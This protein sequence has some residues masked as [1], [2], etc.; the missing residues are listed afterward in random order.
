MAVTRG[1]V[2][3]PVRGP[4][5]FTVEASSSPPAVAPDAPTGVIAVAGDT[6][7]S[8]SFSAPASNGGSAITGY[9]VTSSPSGLT[10]S[11]ASSP[12]VVTGLRNG[13]AY[14]F[15]A[16]AT[17]AIGTSGASSASAPVV[18]TFNIAAAFTG[19]DAGWVHDT[20]SAANL[21]QTSA[22]SGAVSLHS[23]IGYIADLGPSARP[24]LQ[25]TSAS[26][27]IWS[28]V[29]R[30]YGA[31]LAPALSTFTAGTGWVESGGTATA[32]AGTASTFSVP[33]TLT[34][35]VMYLVA[36]TLTRTGGACTAQFTGGT[37]VAGVA[38]NTDGSYFDLL[39]AGTGNTTLE[40]S[41]DA[42]FA[43]TIRQVRVHEV[44]SYTNM[45]ARY[46]AVDDFM[47]SANLNLSAS[48][49]L[50][51]GVSLRSY[52]SVLA[53]T[54][55]A[56]GNYLASQ[57]G[58]AEIIQASGWAARL[59][60]DTNSATSTVPAGNTP[61]IYNPSEQVLTGIYDIA[62]ASIAAEVSLRVR[63]VLPT[64]TTSGTTTGGGNL[65]NSAITIGRGFQGSNRHQGLIRR[66]FGINRPLT[67]GE[68]LAFE[69]WL[70]EGTCYGAWLGDSTSAPLS[71]AQLLPVAVRTSSFV[72]GLVLG[73]AD[74]AKSGDRIAD[75]KTLWTALT[76][77]QALEV[78][79]VFIGQNDVKGRV[80]NSGVSLATVIAD[81]QDLI[82]TINADKP[83]GCKVVVCALT[84]SKGWL[85]AATNPTAAN[86]AW[87]GLNDAIMGRGSSPITGV[88]ARVDGYLAA[89]DDG[90]GRLAAEWNYNNDDV[91]PSSAAR[92]LHIAP[93]VR[94]AIEGLALLPIAA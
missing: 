25:A 13:I 81:Y 52:Q 37:T 47:Q 21:Y 51:M 34:P 40:F 12:L 41:K 76:N 14:T 10:A 23:P 91:H 30:T 35:G 11:G 64:Q 78:V 53:Q 79:V 93:V 68:I 94:A 54:P 61:L 59:R 58:S 45:G 42:S 77:K 15:T 85:D 82:N 74:L 50:T 72:G 49:K 29:P 69:G 89:L 88:D 71:S 4:C 1:P 19:S 56:F 33:M 46:D 55:L 60:G 43:G 39:V 70:R 62:G 7:A 38:R 6:Q 8:V 75:Q 73:A 28:G 17:N 9:T 67:A 31:N 18:P 84:P 90:T 57:T 65:A 27:P 3:G 36:V 87:A 44:L 63:G 22:A 26:R 32:T 80:G 16:T 48:D 86:A 24:C 66:T 92:I 2:E 83:S 5:D 20:V